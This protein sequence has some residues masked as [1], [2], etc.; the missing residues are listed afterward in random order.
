MI[1]LLHVALDF[2]SQYVYISNDDRQI[3]LQAKTSLYSNCELWAKK[4][5]SNL[6]DITMGSYDGAESC[7]LV[8][9]YLL[10]LIKEEIRDS[11]DFA[12]YRDD[13][14]GVSK[15]TPRQTDLIKKKLCTIFSKNGLR[16]TIETNPQ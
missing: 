13:G 9:A 14:L 6:F 1:D 10:C 16:I 3:I 4:T 5:L 8:G 11:C 2:A 15:V 7:E 12:L